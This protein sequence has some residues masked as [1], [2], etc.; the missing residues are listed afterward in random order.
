VTVQRRVSILTGMRTRSF[1]IITIVVLLAVAVVAL[2][3]PSGG[4]LHRM[5][6][7]MHGR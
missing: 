4:R 5:F 6:A 2:H 3:G 7:A 1:V